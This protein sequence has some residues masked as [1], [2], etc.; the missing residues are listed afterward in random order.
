MCICKVH[1][2]EKQH[3]REIKVHG[4]I[5]KIHGILQRFISNAYISTSLQ[6]RQERNPAYMKVSE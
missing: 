1:V 5:R 4:A 2:L 3:G 6:N